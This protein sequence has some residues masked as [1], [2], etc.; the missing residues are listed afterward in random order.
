MKELSPPSVNLKKLFEKETL[1]SEPILIVISPGADPSQ[2]LQELAEQT[3]GH[4][5]YH[6]VI[7]IICKNSDICLI[8]E[9][10]QMYLSKKK[11]CLDIDS[12]YIQVVCF[13]N[14][15]YIELAVKNNLLQ[16][17]IY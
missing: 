5:K 7:K 13:V 16:Y 1:P 3:V 10:P 12:H 15:N 6:Q 9:K 11:T 4:D 2:E 8:Q 14:S 17:P